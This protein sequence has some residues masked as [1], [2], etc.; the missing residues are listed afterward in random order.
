MSNNVTI[1]LVA[2]NDKVRSTLGAT[3]DMLKAF[4][5]KVLAGFAVIG[6]AMAGQKLF[7]WGAN[8]VA[9][10]AESEEAEAKLAQVLQSTG[11]AAGYTKEQLVALSEQLQETTKFEAETTQGAM[12]IL[13]TFR[14][15]RGDTFIDAT[16]AAQDM[17]TV[18]GT[19]LNGAAM[20]LGKALNDP[21]AGIKALTRAGV[22]FTEQQ[23]EMINKLVESG[24]VIGAQQMI[25]EELRHEFGGAAEAVGDTFA[26]KLEQMKNRF[27]DMAESLG[28]IIIEGLSA[29][30]PVIDGIANFLENLIPIVEE[31]TTGFAAMFNESGSVL[32][33]FFE[34]LVDEAILLYTT[35]E[36]TFENA[37]KIAEYSFK[38]MA[39]AGVQTFE[40]LKH[41]FTE[42][43]PAYLQWFGDN[44]V[45]IL[46]DLNNFQGAILLNMGK[47]ILNFLGAVK[48]ALKGKGF[49]F[50]FTSLLEG[51]EM[52][53]KEFPKIAER[54]IGNTEKELAN[55]VNRL[56][57]ELG[58][59]FGRKFQANKDALAGMFKKA[60]KEAVDMA[61]KADLTFDP[62][63]FTT[64]GKEDKE[65]KDKTKTT[66]KAKDEAPVFE[67]LLS[68]NKRI[69][70]AAGAT[71]PEEELKDATEE[72][73]DVNK[74]LI[75]SL[76]GNAP[77]LEKLQ[78]D[79]SASIQANFEKTLEDF[80]KTVEGFAT[81]TPQ[82]FGNA[83]QVLG[84]FSPVMSDGS[85]AA[86]AS[87]F[88]TFGQVAEAA[89]LPGISP[90]DLKT[91]DGFGEMQQMLV[92]MRATN[93][94]LAELRDLQGVN[95]D[96]TKLVAENVDS[97]G[98]L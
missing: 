85:R 40:S 43:L 23:E 49:D 37:A 28:A 96:T 6:A 67:E 57:D 3:E 1:D 27:G 55:D 89:D 26:G 93:S 9:A 34:L 47:N 13:A 91:P 31:V 69:Q 92:E 94:L 45:A 12:S 32:K 90:L 84:D 98:R 2:N 8:F 58:N 87:V 41:W 82:T 18:L 25:L 17:A 38:L 56:G 70:D 19:D 95:N 81:Q 5:G 15:I 97:V 50:K 11:N 30:L 53:M 73:I 16:K 75:A 74:D 51:F 36:F 48:D 83:T 4:G 61:G 39:L 44:W 62:S 29:I 88:D 46:K 68:L 71:T 14:N 24:D 66:E 42:A 59:D 60:D 21:V 76:E 86:D 22:S 64:K 79:L 80:A 54:E 35:L 77:T 7:E 20:Q 10:A 78:T 52:T 72:L 65:K 63:Q 33:D